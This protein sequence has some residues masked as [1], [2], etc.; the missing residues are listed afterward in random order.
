MAPAFGGGHPQPKR[1]I[2]EMKKLREEQGAST[3][4][5][6]LCVLPLCLIG[7]C[8]ILMV[9]YYF[10]QSALLESAAYRPAMTVQRIYNDPNATTLIDFGTEPESNLAG[11]REK[12]S[13]EDEPRLPRD[14]Y[15]YFNNGYNASAIEN[16]AEKKMETIINAGTLSP[17]EAIYVEKADPDVGGVTGFISK[18][19]K[20]SVTQAF[21]LP[22]VFRIVG[23]PDKA[24]IKV[25]VTAPVISQTEFVRNVK[26]V[27]D[28]I[29]ELSEKS[30]TVS[31]ITETIGIAF[32]RISDFFKG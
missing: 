14:P 17:V 7:I 32:T 5:E 18:N 1:G 4:I 9:G 30:E 23:L 27:E 2:A 26:F 22:S 15:R 29:E 8:F 20:V 25:E 19:A 10:H 6:Y 12:A 28:I 16:T 31:K 21:K 11:Y 24:E 13:L 3:I